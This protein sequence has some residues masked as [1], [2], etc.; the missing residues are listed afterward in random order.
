ML[1]IVRYGDPILKKHSVVVP[2]INGDI[3]SLVSEMIE[4]MDRGSG[5]GRGCGHVS[6]GMKSS[7]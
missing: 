4:A 6:R 2:D 7:L 1:S 5:V 3:L